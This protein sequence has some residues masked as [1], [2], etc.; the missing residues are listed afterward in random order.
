MPFLAQAQAYMAQT[1]FV[2][3]QDVSKILHNY[4]EDFIV[5]MQRGQFT[6]KLICM[7]GVRDY[8]SAVNKD[9]R[10]PYIDFEAEPDLIVQIK[11]VINALYH[12]EQVFIDIEKHKD[13]LSFLRA[14]SQGIEV[15]KGGTVARA[16]KASQIVAHLDLG[17]LRELCHEQQAFFD[18]ITAI[19]A[20]REQHADALSKLQ[21][22]SHQLGLIMGHTLNNMQPD[23]DKIDYSFLAHFSAVLPGY[24]QDATRYIERYANIIKNQDPTQGKENIKELEDCAVQLL[25][26]INITQNNG[27][28]RA[29]NVAHYVRIARKI[30]T[31]STSTLNQIGHLS[32]AT[33]KTICDNMAKIKEQSVKLLAFSDKLE[34]IFLLAPGT[35]STPVLIKLKE[36][37]N[38][39]LSY[40]ENAAVLGPVSTLDDLHYLQ[41]RL[42]ETTLRNQEAHSRLFKATHVSSAFDDFFQ[43]ILGK[44]NNH[45][46]D[47]SLD[48][49]SIQRSSTT[50]ASLDEPTKTQLIAHYLLMRPY[51]KGFSIALDQDIVTDLM[52]MTGSSSAMTL[53]S[54]YTKKDALKL[55]VQREIATQEMTILS[56]QR[57]MEYLMPKPKNALLCL[58]S[59]TPSRALRFQETDALK[60]Y[61]LPQYEFKLVSG[62]AFEECEIK[63]RTCILKKNNDIFTYRLRPYHGAIQRGIITEEDLKPYIKAE[64]LKKLMDPLWCGLLQMSIDPT[65]CRFEEVAPLLK[66]KDALIVV[67]NQFFYADQKKQVV[68]ALQV[69]DDNRSDFNQ[70]QTKMMKAYR[71]A[72]EVDLQ[73]IT[74][75]TNRIHPE[76]TDEALV[77]YLPAFLS[78]ITEKRHG[79][80]IKK[81]TL[82][83]TIFEVA[84]HV[85]LNF[86]QAHHLYQYY[87]HKKVVI[88]GAL[89][90]FDSFMR[91]S[92]EHAPDGAIGKLSDEHKVRLKA[93]YMIFQPWFMSALA[94][95]QGIDALDKTILYGLQPNYQV[96]LVTSCSAQVLFQ[97]PTEEEKLKACSLT[98]VYFIRMRQRYAIGFCNTNGKYEQQSITR[99][100]MLDLLSS[101]KSGDMIT[102]P[103]HI[104]KINETLIAVK[105]ITLLT[106]KTNPVENTLYIR[107]VGYVF[108]YTV[109]DPYGRIKTGS[110]SKE[111]LKKHQFKNPLTVSQL[112]TALPGLLTS[113]I[114]NGHTRPSPEHSQIAY[115]EL[116]VLGDRFR[117]KLQLALVA[118][119]EKIK[120]FQN[121]AEEAFQSETKATRSSLK[122]PL[123][124]RAFHVIKDPYYSKTVNK[125]ILSLHGD[126]KMYCNPALVK[127]LDGKANGYPF[128]EM[129]DQGVYNQSLLLGHQKQL[130]NL[131][132]LFNVLYCIEKAFVELEALQDNST[133]LGYVTQ[134]T[135]AYI[136]I[137]TLWGLCTTLI[138]DPHMSL[139]ASIIARHYRLIQGFFAEQFTPYSAAYP[140]DGPQTPGTIGI[141]SLWYTLHSF[142]L[143]PEDVLAKKN[144]TPISPEKL[145]EIKA[146]S[147]KLVLGIERVIERSDSYF[148]LFLEIPAI[149]CLFNDL[150]KQL[151]HF[152]SEIYQAGKD[153]KI[154]FIEKLDKKYFADLL[155]LVDRYEMVMG[156]KPGL[157]SGPLQEI[158]NEFYKGLLEPLALT[159]NRHLACLT[160][161]TIINQEVVEAN[162]QQGNVS[163]LQQRINQVNAQSVGAN[164]QLMEIGK[165]V[166]MLAHLIEAMEAYH[167][168]NQQWWFSDVKKQAALQPVK[169][170]IQHAYAE[171]YPKL[172]AENKSRC[173][174]VL[175]TELPQL[176]VAN[177]DLGGFD[178]AYIR[179][180][181]PV[182]SLNSLFY[183]NKREGSRIELGQCCSILMSQ[184][185]NDDLSKI[186]LGSFVAGYIRVIN[187]DPVLNRLYY[188]NKITGT[189]IDLNIDSEAL[190][191]YDSKIVSQE[192]VNGL[193]REELTLIASLINHNHL[194]VAQANLAK[195]DF[196]ITSLNVPTVLEKEQLLAI[197]PLMNHMHNT[198]YDRAHAGN[199]YP[200]VS[201]LVFPRDL[202]L[203][204]QLRSTQ[205]YY[206]LLQDGYRLEVNANY[207]R[208]NYLHQLAESQKELHK[209]IK[210]DYIEASFEKNISKLVKNCL[211]VPELKVEYKKDLEAHL[212]RVKKPLF[213]GCCAKMRSSNPDEVEKD[214]VRRLSEIII[215]RVGDTHEIGFC[216]LKGDYEQRPITDVRLNT[217]LSIYKSGEYIE[218]PTHKDKINETLITLESSGLCRPI[219]LSTDIHHTVQSAL[220]AQ[221]SQFENKSFEIYQQLNEIITAI[222][223]FNAYSTHAQKLF[224]QSKTGATLFEDENTLAKKTE[225]IDALMEIAEDA[226]IKPGQRLRD[227]HAKTQELSQPSY[228]TFKKDMLAYRHFD[229]VSF[230]WLLRCFVSLLTALHL[231]TPAHV[232][233]YQQLNHAISGSLRFF[234]PEL[235]KTTVSVSS[236][237]ALAG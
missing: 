32:G 177:I 66:G 234:K 151:A 30:I 67:N 127:H 36:Y 33:Q 119:D 156:L 117:Q 112:K 180:K 148:K 204:E 46:R 221:M 101:Y 63:E 55:S 65:Q 208:K 149:Y 219:E 129:E 47:I 154:G 193:S 24:L 160:P 179:V 51:V 3:N 113:I 175:V 189:Q 4:R 104:D 96:E 159:S 217:F 118:V 235:E 209:K 207:I 12:F 69:T 121:A 215:V 106:K 236:R 146:H 170:R 140:L 110:I 25:Q 100:E 139:I 153:E 158:L 98:K 210:R 105:S 19:K 90:A 73:L 78:V 133:Q 43:L 107:Q 233:C 186:S 89:T 40:V 125:L 45:S 115:P 181:N 138:A 190:K 59:M 39:L 1:K 74:S 61:P 108:E 176:D 52:S 206:H 213:E 183:V 130:V 224:K 229:Q 49:I 99:P 137:Q 37:Y 126:V 161:E 225:W 28:H 103:E 85:A 34:N 62:E 72:D 18:F 50:L 199:V 75:V 198:Q 195:Y 82:F 80:V 76:L 135:K 150:K 48:E 196:K 197:P 165:I 157:I 141:N 131:K 222:R 185:P 227:L 57:I 14:F 7:E 29:F 79:D 6:E 228:S 22:T 205:H 188:V 178:A 64:K 145:V 174:S 71:L 15:W 172:Q 187:Q 21:P 230:A 123:S 223:G 91:L 102:I 184:L 169:E 211:D 155:L 144:N 31:L 134:L 163:C 220:A 8:F 77:N 11:Q 152:M 162:A 143:I 164:D 109:M 17:F 42:E 68:S 54:L 5:R 60:T 171:A 95:E 203:L 168:L 70:L 166:G 237:P 142:V 201:E 41:L 200:K 120:H 182:K 87:D 128:P 124:P 136:H 94:Q 92:T 2:L 132:R 10:G 83:G 212:R 111:E 20:T 56:N 26:S 86:S 147:K 93:H 194:E 116:V 38:T 27:L 202:K 192:M 122:Q 9:D 191:K 88:R 13:N 84:R 23:S 16:Y 97:Q 58:E 53:T 216:N 173:C 81:T 214:K 226:T 218:S 167:K 232:K 231:Y 44:I 35:L 114:K